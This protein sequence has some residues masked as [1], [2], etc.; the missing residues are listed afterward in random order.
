MA[1]YAIY[2]FY[3]SC[4]VFSALASITRQRAFG[5]PVDWDRVLWTSAYSGFTA[6]FS[7]LVA[8][9]RLGWS[10]PL[11]FAAAIFCGL[12]N[13]KMTT[14]IMDYVYRLVRVALIS[15]AP[16]PAGNGGGDVV[17]PG[18]GGDRADP[19]RD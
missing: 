8:H 3:L 4:Y 17:A 7:S 5:P 15:P 19:R 1:T 12:F 2:I 11:A 13:E 14:L 16:G 9:E 6:V 18:G 10:Q